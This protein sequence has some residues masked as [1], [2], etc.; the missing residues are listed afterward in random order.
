MLV[1]LPDI[2]QGGMGVG[3]SNWQLAHAVSSAGQLGVVS[4]TGIDTVFV[5]RLQDGDLG[6]HMRIALSNFPVPEVADRILET[7]F[8]KDGRNKGEPYRYAPIGSVSGKKEW[9]ELQIVA[10]YAEIFLAKLG[11]CH[12]VGI[13][14]MEKLQLPTLPSLYG[15]IL[16]GVDYVLM[17]AGIPKAIPGILD[18]LSINAETH[19]HL[20]VRNAAKNTSF[21]STFN[22]HNLFTSKLPDLKRPRFLGIITSHILANNLAKKADGYV[23]GFVIEGPT[24]GG[25]NAPPRGP[26]KLNNKSEPIYSERDIP[27]LAKIRDLGR[28]F[29]MAGSYG[30]PEGLVSAKAE[31]AKGVQVGTAFAFCEESG[32]TSDLKSSIIENCRKKLAN[33]FTD[34]RASPTGFPFK[35]LHLH[36]TM[37]ED[38]D[39]KNRKRKCDLGYLR[40]LFQKEDG[41]VGYRCAAEPVQ[42]YLRKLG[43]EEDTTGRKC[44]CN[45]LLA[46]V[47]LGQKQKDGTAEKPI[48]TVGDNVM[49]IIEKL[50]GDR[51]SYKATDVI[52]YLLGKIHS[53]P[54][55]SVS[56][57]NPES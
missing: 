29:W 38:S 54:T 42:N 41:S 35:V 3:V 2:I 43:K 52:T 10:C 9:E 16:A 40:Q 26:L 39:Y 34:A 18:K 19:L 37:S 49:A 44:L 15:S 17:G 4:A 6:H 57:N 53:T 13:N 33:V 46:T 23:D 31:G 28:P 24:A 12:E 8:R 14:F 22:P 25:H 5:R 48:I 55:S 32:M 51:N 27:D 7:Y 11:H 45:A 21:F 56:D 36:G 30:T 50:A 1:K 47:G 20:D